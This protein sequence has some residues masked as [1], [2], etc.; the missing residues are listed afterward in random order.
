MVNIPLFLGFY[1]SQ[2]VQDFFH[3]QYLAKLKYF[4]NLDFPWIRGFPETSATFW[5]E[6]VWRRY[7]LTRLIHWMFFFFGCTK[8]KFKVKM[9]NKVAEQP[10]TVAK[11]FWKTSWIPPQKAEPPKEFFKKRW[12]LPQFSPQ[13]KL[14]SPEVPC[15]LP[16]GCHS[17]PSRSISR[18][19]HRISHHTPCNSFPAE[20]SKQASEKKKR[21]KSTTSLLMAND[22]WGSSRW[23]FLVLSYSQ[24]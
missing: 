14:H 9:S 23:L 5:G 16:H 17:L 8:D 6:V 24:G 20:V 4:T 13:R 21:H 15:V 18:Y 10:S 1:T 2:V 7:N 22:L 3:Q 12:W 19:P 11:Q